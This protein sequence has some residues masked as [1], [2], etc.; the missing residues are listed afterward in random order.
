ILDWVGAKNCFMKLSGRYP[1]ISEEAL[2]ALKPDWILA[3][4]SMGETGDSVLSRFKKFTSLPAVKKNQVRSLKLDELL[5][6]GPRL[7]L[8]AQRLQ[9]LLL[10]L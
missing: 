5:R 1:Q 6:P 8:G 3:F 4:D 10:G 7:V 2:V 9:S